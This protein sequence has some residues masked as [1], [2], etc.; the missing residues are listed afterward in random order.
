MNRLIASL[1]LTLATALTPLSVDAQSMIRSDVNRELEYLKAQRDNLVN[2]RK[3]GDFTEVEFDNANL[4]EVYPVY[5]FVTRGTPL[6]RLLRQEELRSQVMDLNNDGV[7]EIIFHVVSPLHCQGV[8]CPLMIL[9]ADVEAQK[10][11]KIFEGK[12]DRIHYSPEY[13]E[14]GYKTLITS[15]RSTRNILSMNTEAGRYMYSP[16]NFSE[17]VV[18]TSLSDLDKE[19]LEYKNAVTVL[20]RDMGERFLILENKDP[21][22]KS[23]MRGVGDLNKDEDS[24]TF[25]YFTNSDFCNSLGECEL[26]VYDRLESKPSFYFKYAFEK[27]YVG[28]RLPGDLSDIGLFKDNTYT[29]YKWNSSKYSYEYSETKQ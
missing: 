22:L 14:S 9:K 13:E 1:F 28:Q 7:N 3:I 10:W 19:S 16:K 6:E 2:L 27:L 24:E 20:Q 8:V 25:L 5:Q 17:E 11:D 15:Q 26:I 18:F 4:A 12:L 21:A 29:I 23:V